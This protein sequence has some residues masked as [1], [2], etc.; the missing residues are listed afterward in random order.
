M[1]LF[2]LLNL[3][4][5]L[6]CAGILTGQAQ[7]RLSVRFQEASLDQ[8]F[9][10]IEARSNY[11]FLYNNK[12]ITGF[13]RQSALF[14]NA[15]IDEMLNKILG[16]QLSY[17][18]LDGNLIV[19][20]KQEH[21]LKAGRLLL[22]G[23]I[24]DSA[25]IPLSGVSVYIKGTSQGTLSDSTGRFSLPASSGVMLVFHDI[26]YFDKE[27]FVKPG[28]RF[29]IKL[30]KRP[31]QLQEIIITALGV[32]KDYKRVGYAVQQI[33]F[34]KTVIPVSREANIYTSLFGKV[35]GLSIGNSR[36]M[37]NNPEIFLRGKH[38]LIVVDGVPD[39]S[40][41]WDLN[42]DDIASISVLKGP[43]AAALYGQQGANGAIQITTKRGSLSERNFSVTFNS[44]T[45]IQKSFLAIPEVQHS[46]GPGDYF[47]YAFGDGKGGGLYD[48]DYN[49][50]GPRFEG[51]L[52]PQWDSPR[53]GS[54]NLIP[55]PWQSKNDHNLQDFLR[56]GIL[57][58][59][60]IAISGK[61]DWGDFRVSLTQMYQRDV[62]P[63]MHLGITTAN[64]SGGVRFG[65]RF[66]AN[67]VMS[68]NKQY[69][70]NFP[71]VYYGPESPVYELQIWNGSNFDIND[72]RLKNYWQPGKEGIQ[73]QWVEYYRY[74]NPWF[75]AYENLK[76]YYKDVLTGYASVT[77]DFNKHISTDIK[78]AINTFYVNQNTK[79]PVSGLYYGAD[80][81]KGGGYS[82]SYNY[83]FQSNSSVVV[84]MSYDMGDH[85]SAKFTLGGNLQAIQTKSFAAHTTGGLV[86][87]GVYTLQNSSKPIDNAS[88]GR[89]D[90]QIASLFGYLD[91]D[92]KK[93]IFLDV[94]GRADR[95]SGMPKANNTYFYPQAS[96]SF[97]LSDVFDLPSCISFLKLTATA[98]R[99]GEGLPP[100]SFTETYSAG[101]SWQGNASV[102]Y[103]T[104]NTLYSQDIKPEFHTD[105]E[106]GFDIRL[107]NNRY[108]LTMQL[109]KTND[110]PQIFPLSIANT[111]GY[112]YRQVNG[113]IITRK[114]MELT[115]DAA[116]IS[117]KTVRWNMMVNWSSNVSYLKKVY[118][119]LDHDKRIKVGQRYDRLFIAAFERDPRNGAI[120]YHP[121]GTPII[122]EQYPAFYGFYNPDWIIGFTE[123]VSYK[124]FDLTL[125][126]DGCYG[127]KVF[128]YLNYKMW[129]SGTHPASDNQYRYQDWLHRDDP[130][131][132]GSL[133]GKGEVVVSGSLTRDQ[134]GNVIS[135]S[136]KFA[137]N[138][139][140]VLEEDWAKTY[141]AADENNYVSKTYLKLRGITLTYH[142]SKAFTDRIKWLYAGSISLIARNV[143]YLGHTHQI[144]MD[145][146]I[147][148]EESNLETPSM[149]SLGINFSLEF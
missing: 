82:E 9:E 84:N 54:G 98:A 127:G 126:F 77:Y 43:A 17:K 22:K 149:R 145:R 50:W 130:D 20:I 139:T 46:Y 148:T 140:P 93:I 89:S 102:Y 44:T 67:A 60:N 147:H 121:D 19:I 133:I 116:L 76:A 78:S 14:K 118:D 58:T 74:N 23:L 81:Y 59:N 91:L 28:D 8:I 146:W 100:Y 39:N 137:P 115:L 53:D 52:I 24:T 26:G 51:Q 132:K 111:S 55:L 2:L 21:P 106:T 125:E 75:N 30:Q 92:Y 65:P 68:Y 90:S 122:D 16:N 25:G 4:F 87:P 134:N 15:S 86:I 47:Q 57:S 13:P 88:T 120:L 119:T 80:F 104:N 63:N 142:L 61:N 135:D 99:V 94:T 101:T 29:S 97:M 48:Y 129:Q 144:D 37:Y 136:R 108:G 66:K 56:T 73:Q 72:P 83:Y 45:E 32:K 105:Y 85:I 12:D 113:L 95:N 123:A 71:S 69:T 138:T 11:K 36:Y 62:S 5:C 35:A 3:L 31:Q 1:K 18:I 6:C 110:G 107:F 70:P 124:N 40:D 141:E 128:N 41:S 42:A 131:Y 64:I 38:P 10:K 49:V 33:D 27:S 117:N 96:L 103:A 112:G 109:Y 143:L 79:Y 7:G 114:G 34:A